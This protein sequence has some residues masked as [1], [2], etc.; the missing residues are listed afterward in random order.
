MTNGDRDGM[1]RVRMRGPGSVGFTAVPVNG[2]YQEE[3]KEGQNETK[4]QT[5]SM[6]SQC[7]C[8]SFLS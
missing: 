8:V 6:N 3:A 7:V 4:C 1:S 5:S 2:G